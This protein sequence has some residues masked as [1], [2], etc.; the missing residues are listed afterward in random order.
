[1]QISIQILCFNVESESE[2]KLIRSIGKRKGLTGIPLSLRV[3]P[4]VDAQVIRV[5][6]IYCALNN[7]TFKFFLTEHTFK[8]EYKC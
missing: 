8:Y 4:D 3:N 5:L 7:N 2:L 6:M 1:M